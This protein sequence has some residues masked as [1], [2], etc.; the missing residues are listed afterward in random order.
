MSLKLANASRPGSNIK[1]R[2]KMDHMSTSMSDVKGEKPCEQSVLD[3]PN[4]YEQ[5]IQKL[6]GDVR[7]HIRIEQQLKLHI[8]SIQNKLEELERQKDGPNK[9]QQDQ[10]DL[11]K[12]DKRR[13]DELITI[14]ENQVDKLNQSLAVATQKI[15]KL[16][17]AAS[18]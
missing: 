1:T 17:E 15:S 14:K 10:I 4:D 11:L 2:S 7:N 9:K 8:E 12:R 16:E 18:S 6:E 13:M 5:M 3:V